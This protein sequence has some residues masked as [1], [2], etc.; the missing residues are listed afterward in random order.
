MTLSDLQGSFQR[1]VFS[2]NNGI[3]IY[4]VN[5]LSNKLKFS[6]C[7]LTLN[8]MSLS[9]LIVMKSVG[10]TERYKVMKCIKMICAYV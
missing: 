10:K 4:D 6:F 9:R 8:A 2:I 5:K 7:F 1:F 3:H